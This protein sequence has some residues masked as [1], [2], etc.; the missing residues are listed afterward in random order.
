[1]N[2]RSTAY[3]GLEKAVRDGIVRTDDE[4]LVMNTG[5]GLKDIRTAMTAV[6]PAP[7]IA[8]SLKELKKFLKK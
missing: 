6:T 3:A 4:I 7:V 8:P 5:S 1:V 2:Q